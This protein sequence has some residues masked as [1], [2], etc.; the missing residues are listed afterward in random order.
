M[1]IVIHGVGAFQADG[2]DGCCCGTSYHQYLT[3]SIVT[4]DFNTFPG[5]AA[6]PGDRIVVA[7]YADQ[8]PYN[9]G[10]TLDGLDIF[11][12]NFVCNL[13]PSNYLYFDNPVYT[14]G[15]G[16]L[17]CISTLD[18]TRL[19][20]PYGNT[21]VQTYNYPYPYQ[22]D[23]VV[24]HWWI[25]RGADTNPYVP[26][27]FTRTTLTRGGDGYFNLSITPPND[28][29]C[30]LGVLYPSLSTGFP[31]NAFGI[32]NAPFTGSKFNYGADGTNL[33]TLI[34]SMTIDPVQT[35]GITSYTSNGTGLASSINF[36][37]PNV[38]PAGQ[39]INLRSGATNQV[40]SWTADYILLNAAPTKTL[41]TMS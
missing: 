14:R 22:V 39:T 29:C 36:F 16:W 40:S 18:N 41:T 26:G 17:W 38:G 19:G 2:Q 31:D 28:N 4:A 12:N 30:V 24:Y 20:A 25:I 11:G 6:Q 8:F 33:A 9:N 23:H 3:N 34:G 37:H 35:G 7:Y 10:G 27:S 5:Y 15:P 32:T 21:V 13:N 1:S